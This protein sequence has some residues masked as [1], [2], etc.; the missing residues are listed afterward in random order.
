MSLHGKQRRAAG[1]SHRPSGNALAKF[2]KND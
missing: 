1:N 2:K